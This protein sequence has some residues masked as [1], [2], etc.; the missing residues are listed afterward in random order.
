MRSEDVIPAG[1]LKG[2]Q[3]DRL[4]TLDAFISRLQA[5][6]SMLAGEACPGAPRYELHG[7]YIHAPV[8][9]WFAAG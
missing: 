1:E 2:S 4:K 9:P 8:W 3:E 6:R 7:R 5:M